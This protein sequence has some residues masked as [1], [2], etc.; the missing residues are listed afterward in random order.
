MQRCILNVAIRPTA[1]TRKDKTAGCSST[2]PLVVW[3]YQGSS[4]PLWCKQFMVESSTDA[5]WTSNSLCLKGTNNNSKKLRTVWE[6]MF[7]NYICMQS[8]INIYIYGRTMV[9]I[10][11]DHKPIETKFRKHYWQHPNGYNACYWSYKSITSKCNIKEVGN[12]N[13]RFPFSNI[14][15]QQGWRTKTRAGF[16]N[17]W[18]RWYGHLGKRGLGTSWDP[19]IY[20]SYWPTICRNSKAHKTRQSTAIS[21][22]DDFSW[23]TRH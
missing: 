14:Y 13:S 23:M 20:K 22:N 7:G 8:L 9:T 1:R 2:C 18:Y 16:I 21:E 12:A 4:N 19:R 6:K 11:T 3:C 17:K 5:R 10:R 15:R